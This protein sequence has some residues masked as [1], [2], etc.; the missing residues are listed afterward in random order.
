MLAEARLLQQN[1]VNQLVQLAET[2]QKLF[3]FRAPTGSGKTFMMADFM[4]RMLSKMDN[5]VF[6]ISTRSKARL[7]R[8]NYDKFCEYRDKGFFPNLNPYLINTNISGEERLFI[9]SG[10]NIYILPSDLNKKGGKLMQ[11]ALTNFFINTT[12][13]LYGENKTIYLIKDEC[14]IATKNLD[15]SQSY[16]AK[17]FYFSATP[18]LDKGQ[19]PDVIIKDEDAENAKLIKTVE[20]GDEQDTLEQ[21][22]QKYQEIKDDYVN[23]LGVNPCLMVQ[24]SNSVKGKE[25]L[26]EIFSVLGRHTDLKWM[27]ILDENKQ[28][29]DTNDSIKNKLPVSKWKEFAKD[30]GSTINVI[31][32]KIAISEGWDIP[33][34]CM[35]YQI[36]DTKSKQLD[37]QVMGRVKRNPR[38]IDYETLPQDAQ[39]LTETA[40]IWGIKPK[41]CKKSFRVNLKENFNISSNFKIRT[42]TLK[43]LTQKEYFNLSEFLE[44][45][46]SKPA[47]SGIFDIHRKLQ[48]M[49][50]QTKTMIYE[51]ADS[52]Q[53]WWKAADYL[54]SIEKESNKY[55]ADYE[56]SMQECKETVSLPLDT[57][58]TDNGNYQNIAEWLWKRKDGHDKFSFDSEAEREWATILKDACSTHIGYLE[59]E[60][61]LEDKRKVYLW[62]KNYLPNSPIKF[63]YYMGSVLNSYPDFIM[64]DRQGRIHIFEVKSVN[65]SGNMVIDETLYNE[66]IAELKKCYKQASRITRQ[67]FYLPTMQGENWQITRFK[68]GTEDTISREEFIKSISE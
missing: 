32:F 67:I 25:E 63:E 53:K 7:D 6:L 16:F 31:I 19:I 49:D 3:V 21:A 23:K 28:Q 14:H 30:N 18:K 61:L 60:S 59:E 47:H 66:K 36:R 65:K 9:P 29:C 41:D 2:E 45:Q 43:P 42:T 48:S 50:G 44:S 13:E 1:A 35:L 15:I 4:N 27:L 33:R 64:K 8:Q 26:H 62:G 52:F 56:Q 34:A 12:S 54:D 38:L 46:K 11:G 17:S 39:K 5:L 40:W 10:Y 20:W 37:D 51:Y 22:I 55:Y 68:N 24:I 58:Y 57:Y